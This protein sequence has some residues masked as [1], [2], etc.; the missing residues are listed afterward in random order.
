[1]AVTVANEESMRS[2][3]P[4]LALLLLVPA[5]SLSALGAMVL[6]PG[7]ALAKGLFVALKIWLVAFPVVW[8]LLVDKGRLSLSPARRGGWG[9]AVASGLAISGAILLTYWLLGDWLIDKGFFREK[10]KGLGL[11][12]PVM[13][14]GCVAYWVLVNSVL[15]EYVW[16]WFVC[17][18]CEELARPWVAAALSALFFT[19]HHIVAMSVYFGAAAVAICSAGVF[20]GG[21]IWS[22]MYV[23]YRSVWPGYVSH[24]IV[25]LCMFA[26]GAWMIFGGG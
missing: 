18:K 2:G 9:V 7:T 19:L 20:L 3:R 25:D 24:A 13:Y 11:G 26:I 12:S 5:P 16:R 10:I 15:E 14:A 1:M 17:A 4:I 6:F 21:L 23:R 8:L 22:L